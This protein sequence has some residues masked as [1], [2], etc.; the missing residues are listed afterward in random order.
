MP[1]PSLHMQRRFVSYAIPQGQKE[2]NGEPMPVFPPVTIIT[3]PVKSGTSSSVN[4][5][6]G[7]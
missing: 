2:T 5:G 7:G 3:F 1:S 6:A 4:L